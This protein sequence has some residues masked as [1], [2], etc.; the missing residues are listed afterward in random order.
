[1]NF[2]RAGFEPFCANPEGLNRINDFIRDKELSQA[3]GGDV[4]KRNGSKPARRNFIEQPSHGRAEFFALP[5]ASAALRRRRPLGLLYFG[6]G[7]GLVGIEKTE[8]M[9]WLDHVNARLDLLLSDLLVQLVHLGPM[10]LRLVVM[11]SVITVVEPDRIIKL[12]V[13]A[14][15]PGDG[16]I[17]VPA[18]M[19]V[20][21]VKL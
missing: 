20:I 13:A 19:T 1:M 17:R 14:H 4:S 16:F 11:L 10:D 5:R 9:R 2:V 8:G 12:A 15:S 18:E 7:L 6:V 3:P 21:P